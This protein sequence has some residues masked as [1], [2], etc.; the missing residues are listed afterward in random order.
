MVTHVQDVNG[1]GSGNTATVNIT[2]TVGNTLVLTVKSIGNLTDNPSSYGISSVIDSA[3]NNWQYSS[4]V[5]N[6]IPPVDGAPTNTIYGR[7]TMCGIAYC[8]NAQAITSVTATFSNVAAFFSYACALEFTFTNAPTN[9]SFLTSAANSGYIPSSTSVTSPTITW[10]TPTE[11]VAVGCTASSNIF[12]S[13][14]YIFASTVDVTNTVYYL[15]FSGQ[16][17]QNVNWTT[18]DGSTFTY[19]SAIM[20]IGNTLINASSSLSAA[21]GLIGTGVSALNEIPHAIAANGTVIAQPDVIFPE[22]SNTIFG[23]A[24]F[25][26]ASMVIQPAASVIPSSGGYLSA[27][28]TTGI[29]AR[30][31]GTATVAVSSSYASSSNMVAAEGTVI[32]TSSV[33][34]LYYATLTAGSDMTALPPWAGIPIV[35]SGSGNTQATWYRPWFEFV[36]AQ[37]NSISYPTGG[38]TLTIPVTT[39]SYE[40]FVA[41][42]VTISSL[43][44]VQIP[45]QIQDSANNKWF[46]GVVSSADAGTLWYPIYNA[47]TVYDT[48]LQKYVQSSIIFASNDF[49]NSN[50]NP[51]TSITLTAGYEVTSI[52]TVFASFNVLTPLIHD[53]DPD[54]YLQVQAYGSTASLFGQTD[55]FTGTSQLTEEPT[56]YILPTDGGNLPGWGS[57]SSLVLA[58]G[59]AAA[60]WTALTAYNYV[61]FEPE[62]TSGFMLADGPSVTNAS[63]GMVEAGNYDVTWS[64]GSQDYYGAAI[65]ALSLW[66]EYLFLQ[67]QSTLTASY[68]VIWFADALLQ[69]QSALTGYVVEGIT[70]I[71][72]HQPCWQ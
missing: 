11:C 15:G 21:G 61:N 13:S 12:T 31:Q 7:Y 71:P 33:T 5:S 1:A 58:L 45:L 59:G 64:G 50:L 42:F 44:G 23:N 26:A 48:T 55:N 22:V 4:A 72:E 53:L 9:I 19:A 10:N 8:T 2:T 49:P 68:E 32:A 6:Q 17:N 41:L 69:G 14:N 56:G 36:Q 29:I 25:Y 24:S 39:S 30:P 28:A 66:S 62:I 70:C 57:T 40:N 43:A 63:Y 18:S 3:G 35:L 60:P 20:L 38:F 47:G 54:R 52:S 37:S 34:F 51:I 16:G 27:I 65:I 46:I 67:A